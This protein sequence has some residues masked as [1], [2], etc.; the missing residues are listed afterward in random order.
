MARYLLVLGRD[1]EL[2]KLELF[3]YLGSHNIDYKILESE[4][5]CLA[6]DSKSLNTSKTIADLGGLVKIAI[7]CENLDS[8]ELYQGKSEKLD[9]T[10]SNYGQPNPNIVYSLK[11][12]LKKRFKDEGLKAIIRNPHNPSEDAV[13]PTRISRSSM[14]E[15]IVF[16]KGVYITQSVSDP[17]EIKSRDINRPAQRPL[18]VISIRLAKILIN[19]SGA[20]PGNILLDPF[21]GIGTILQEALLKNINAIGIDL[22]NDC[23]MA[24]RKNLNWLRENYRFNAKDKLICGDAAKLSSLVKEQIDVAVTEPYLGPFL[25]KKPHSVTALK[26]VTELRP[27]YKAVMR[28]LRAVVKKKVIIIV[29]RFDTVDGKKINL[30]FIEFTQGFKVTQEPILYQ[31]QKSTITRE[32]WIL[33]KI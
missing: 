29:P 28:E 11:L 20:K 22:S 5:N 9:Y 6:I 19:L 23:I 30:N 18:H 13:S 15:L 16:H 3:S 2:S 32:I 12:Y 24:S 4:D 10:I 21:C 14:L 1:I 26:I 31:A 8:V 25:T 33:E 27:M 7:F 17:R